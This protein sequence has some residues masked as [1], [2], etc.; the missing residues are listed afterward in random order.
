MVHTLMGITQVAGTL[1]RFRVLNAD[2]A[3]GGLAAADGKP[4]RSHA[5]KL[6][7]RRP[8]H[9]GS[10]PHRRAGQGKGMPLAWE[11]FLSQLLHALRAQEVGH[12]LAHA[13][14]YGLLD[15][16]H[17]NEDALIG[18]SIFTDVLFSLLLCMLVVTEDMW[19]SMAQ[20]PKGFVKAALPSGKSY[21]RTTP[22]PDLA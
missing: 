16:L 1:D 21:I 7:A 8:L 22:Q 14:D 3:S 9:G 19:G 20:F 12:V 17:H 4:L 13:P 18:Q 10:Q 6:A 11:V 5:C 2:P 15:Y